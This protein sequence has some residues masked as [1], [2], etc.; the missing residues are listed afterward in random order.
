MSGQSIIIM[1]V[2]GSGKSSIGARLAEHI[3]AKFIDGDDLHP[4]NNID[5]MS[6]G[7]PL[8]DEDRLPW[9]ARLNDVSYSLYKKNELGIIVCSSLK[10]IYRDILRQGSPDV[11]FLWLH[12]SYE[13]ILQ[14]MQARKGHFMPVE[15][16]KTQFATLELP[17]AQELDVLQVDI[18]GSYQQ[19]VERS[20]QAL[21]AAG[22]LSVE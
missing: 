1:G 20:Y 9:L 19:V 18:D 8:N 6:S 5:K 11:H 12:G 3:C 4:R 7:Q 15:L 21:L 22:V 14:R 13:L 2:S 10:H 17:T 16:L